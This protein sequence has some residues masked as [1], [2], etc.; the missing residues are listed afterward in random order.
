MPI[1][2]IAVQDVKAVL[3]KITSRGALV[4]AKKIREWIGA[5]FKYAAMLELTDRNPAAVLSGYLIQN[6]TVKNL[7][8]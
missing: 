6:E 4:M 3:D 7:C 8:S 5:V 1:D 2:K